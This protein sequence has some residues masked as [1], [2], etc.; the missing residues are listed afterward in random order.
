MT[1]SKEVVAKVGDEVLYKSDLKDLYHP[2]MSKE[3]SIKITDNFINNW[4]KNQILLQKAKGSLTEKEEDDIE[5][6]VRN[7]KNDLLINSYKANIVSQNIDS[8]IPE[9]EINKFYYEN[10][11]IFK[12]NEDMLKFRMISYQSNDK[13]AGKMKELL[14]K[15]DSISIN[16]LMT[17]DFLFQAIQTNDSI[18]IKF[19]DFVKKYPI[20]TKVSKESFLQ[21]SSAIELNDSNITY[22]FYVKSFLRSGETAP[23]QFVKSDVSKMIIHQKKLKYIQD[24]ENKLI[25][26]AIQNKTYEKY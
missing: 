14:K 17:G 24:I 13:N 2:N 7:Y 6:M 4:A 5:E 12:L 21:N 3:D 23:I 1:R 16:A 25:K 8:L 20:V 18:W 22:Y 10:L 11:H 9:N 26:E 19:E 15:N